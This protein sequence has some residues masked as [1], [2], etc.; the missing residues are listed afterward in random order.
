MPQCWACWD[1]NEE[2]TFIRPCRGCLDP[3]L[4]YIHSKCMDQFI[5]NLPSVN[6]TEIDMPPDLSLWESLWYVHTEE[7]LPLLEFKCTRCLDPY[8]TEVE[9]YS[10]LTSLIKVH[11]SLLFALIGLFMCSA[12][13]VTSS[14]ALLIHGDSDLLEMPIFSF[15]GIR[16][17]TVRVWSIILCIGY[18][19]VNVLM[20]CFVGFKIPP[21]RIV[22][23]LNAD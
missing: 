3:D 17:L 14:I 15:F 1:T 7:S 16:G 4:Q 20:W 6:Y 5:N 11:S 18:V 9:Y 10:R 2:E 12:I 8:V 23:I 22:H 21:F 13:V 19:F